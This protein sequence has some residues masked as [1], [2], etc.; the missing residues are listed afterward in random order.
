MSK[1]YQKIT[2]LIGGTPLLEL[3]NYEKKNNLEA[4]GA[5][6]KTSFATVRVYACLSRLSCGEMSKGD[7]QQV[8]P[9]ELSPLRVDMARAQ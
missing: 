3:A 5:S 7:T 2:D 8:P 1:I 6:L 9:F 4:T